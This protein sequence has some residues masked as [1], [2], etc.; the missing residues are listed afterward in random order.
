M[1]FINSAEEAHLQHNKP[2]PTLKILNCRKYFFQKLTLFSQGNNVIDDAA[3]H[4]DDFLSRDTCVSSILLD[5]PIR[6][7]QTY[8]HIGNY[9]L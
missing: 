2:K 9:D 4:V 6:S 8:L 5:R 1:G 7:K 3:S